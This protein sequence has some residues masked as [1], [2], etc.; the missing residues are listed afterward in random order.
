MHGH[1]PNL[2]SCTLSGFFAN[3]PGNAG[4]NRGVMG[5]PFFLKNFELPALQLVCPKPVSYSGFFDCT[6]TQSLKV[7]LY[8]NSFI[9][10]NGIQRQAKR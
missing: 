3:G 4:S 9:N 1:R 5:Q 8:A 7:Y 10:Q 6:A 2:V